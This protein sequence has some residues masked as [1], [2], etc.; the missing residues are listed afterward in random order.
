MSEGPID[1]HPRQ[2]TVSSTGLDPKLGGLLCYLLGF[3]T[4]IVFLIIEKQDRLIRFHAW[5]ST[6]T[7]GGLFVLQLVA[8]FIPLIGRP[9]GVLI[10]PV[11]LILWILLMYQAYQGQRFKLPWVG[12]WAEG[13]VANGS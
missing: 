4:G 9:I 1:E 8:R 7:F 12:N 10:V 6:A 13:Q 11:S 3:I 2:E 5:Q